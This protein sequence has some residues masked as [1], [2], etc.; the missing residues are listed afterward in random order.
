VRRLVTL[1][2]QRQLH[3]QLAVLFCELLD[4]LTLLAELSLKPGKRQ[5]SGGRRARARA[6]VCVCVCVC[7]CVYV[8]EWWLVEAAEAISECVRNTARKSIC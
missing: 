8:C 4:L 7:V 5:P 3:Y 6:R 1:A 2:L